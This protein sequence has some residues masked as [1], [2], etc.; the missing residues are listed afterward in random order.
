[1]AAETLTVESWYCVNSPKHGSPE[2]D[3]RTAV[4]ENTVISADRRSVVIEIEGFGGE[5]MWLDRIY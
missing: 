3:K 4:V 1:M 5:G 2:T